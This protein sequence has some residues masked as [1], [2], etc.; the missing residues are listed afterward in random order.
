MEYVKRER[1]KRD[2]QVI[3]HMDV[4][5]MESVRQGMERMN[6]VVQRIVNRLMEVVEKII[7]QQHGP[8][9]GIVAYNSKRDMDIM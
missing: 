5:T 7:V 1:I 9:H 6:I 8:L 2:V 3:V 4:I